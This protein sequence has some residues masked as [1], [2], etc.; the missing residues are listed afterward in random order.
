MIVA[1]RRMAGGGSLGP[2]FA[3]K[4]CVTG[5]ACGAISRTPPIAVTLESPASRTVSSGPLGAERRNCAGTSNTAS[6]P[7]WR[8]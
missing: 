4:V 1:P 7:F 6:R 5:S 2:T 3:S 8:E